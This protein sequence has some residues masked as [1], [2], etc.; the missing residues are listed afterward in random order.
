[1]YRHMT[2]I[3]HCTKLTITS[4]LVVET[5]L[6]RKAS[7]AE[8]GENYTNPEK[9]TEDDEA[10]A[11]KKAKGTASPTFREYNVSCRSQ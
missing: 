5:N 3:F 10:P 7:D 2:N 9:A 4:V 8:D 11:A 1:M 6:K